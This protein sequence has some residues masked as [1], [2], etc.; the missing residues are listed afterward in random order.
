[1]IKKQ[2]NE[3]LALLADNDE[4]K[5]EKQTQFPNLFNVANFLG[6]G[7][8]KIG[9]KGL[10]SKSITPEQAKNLA[11]WLLGVSYIEDDELADMIA[12]VRALVMPHDKVMIPFEPKIH[13]IK[14]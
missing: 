10:S 1:M 7:L 9:D 2:E 5:D 13:K 6:T 12:Q 8:I 14:K 11:V 4:V 3:I